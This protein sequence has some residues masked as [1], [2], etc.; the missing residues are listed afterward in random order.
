MR[1][2]IE[3]NIACSK[4][5]LLELLLRDKGH[6]V[7]PE[8]VHEWGEWLSLF[9]RDPKRWAFGFQMKVLSAFVRSDYAEPVSIIERSMLSTRHVFGQLL[10]NQNL[11]AHKEWDLFRAMA[12]QFAWAPDAIIFIDCPPDVCLER[13]QKR[14]RAAEAQVELDYLRK[15]DFMYAQ[16]LKYF[17]GE[18]VTIDGNR[19]LEQVYKD[20]ADAVAR[21]VPEHGV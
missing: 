20:V 9:Y 2:C 1:I 7:Y 18:V 3:G 10:F 5:S 21:L 14:G 6:A 19:P 11:L 16:M 8:P 12:E 17:E 4:S 13:L 15:I